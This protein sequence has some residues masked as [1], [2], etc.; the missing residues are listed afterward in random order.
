MARLEE[1]TGT[2]RAHRLQRAE[3]ERSYAAIIHRVFFDRDSVDFRVMVD[4]LNLVDGFWLDPVQRYSFPPPPYALNTSFREEP[5]TIGDSVRLPG[6]FT[7]PNGPGPFASVVI[8]HGAGPHDRDGTFLGN[9]MYRDLAQGLATRGVAVLRYEKRTR[10]LAASMVF[11]KLT[12]EQEVLD[13]AR[14]AVHFLR[15]RPEVDTGRLSVVG[16]GIGGMMAP[17]LAAQ[18]AGIK[19]IA[20]MAAPARR[21][22]DVLLD[23]FV[24]VSRN[25]DS[26]SA[27]QR[28]ELEAQ[29]RMVR[30]IQKRR[31]APKTMIA[32]I[33]AS[34][35]YAL[36]G[37]DQL[38]VAAK[39]SIPILVLQ[40]GKDFQ[41]PAGEFE[42]WK[43]A[44]A[45]HASARFLFC[46]KCYHQFIET[47]SA[48][49]PKNYAEE[50]HVAL[51][52][53]K[54]LARWA[55]RK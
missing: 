45:R 37:Y 22:E 31:L 15:S 16:H 28:S 25:S 46:E 20:L 39:R 32:G 36:R 42:L 21:L 35:Y 19:G 14:A 8:L 40:G 55:K 10:V 48:P 50:G 41:T 34:Y 43:R 29:I 26:L 52:V 53:V 24:F 23:Q 17:R 7:I 27:G 2:Y 54:E 18:H 3:M 47:E 44:L 51:D 38:L 11:S 13:D 33:P 1:K 12:I 9:K 30:D 49:G 6:T 4:S 5:V